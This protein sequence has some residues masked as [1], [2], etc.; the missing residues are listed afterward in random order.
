MK[1][2]VLIV[3]DERSMCELL[4]IDL[5]LRD[6]E[7][8]WHNSAEEGLQTL[9]DQTFDA[10]LT[11]LRLGATDGLA[12]LRKA[13]EVDP[14]IVV[15]LMTAYATVQTAVAAMKDGAADY[16][17]KPLSFDRVHHALDRALESR[18]LVDEN[19]D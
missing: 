8:V 16:L 5:R 9:S 14:G 3:D 6:F 7:P 11:D 15:L 17:E 1:P 13:K 19:R 12:V 4:E 2:R 10:V 18:R